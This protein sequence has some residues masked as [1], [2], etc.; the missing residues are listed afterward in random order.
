MQTGILGERTRASVNAIP[1]SS[2]QHNTNILD[3]KYHYSR[4]RPFRKM[5]VSWGRAGK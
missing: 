5:A 3:Y 1:N 4:K 2:E